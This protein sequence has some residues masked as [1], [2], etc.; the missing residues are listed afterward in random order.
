ML[1]TFGAFTISSNLR[2]INLLL[3]YISLM[4]E[5]ELIDEQSM[6]VCSR[7]LCITRCVHDE[8]TS[9]CM[10]LKSLTG[11]ATDVSAKEAS[12]ARVV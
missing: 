8:S 2:R 5:P 3:D 10:D 9:E 1:L 4:L 6:G 11:L 12:Q 7:L